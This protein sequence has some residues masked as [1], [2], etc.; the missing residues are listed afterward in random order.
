MFFRNLSLKFPS[1]RK[2]GYFKASDF[3]QKGKVAN[4]DNYSFTR[5]SGKWQEGARSESAKPCSH[6]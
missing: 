5:E 6:S 3:I 2:T 4:G 1:L